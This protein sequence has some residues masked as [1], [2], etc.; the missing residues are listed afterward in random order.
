MQQTLKKMFSFPIQ[1]TNRKSNRKLHELPAHDVKLFGYHR[2]V[3][4]RICFR[5]SEQVRFDPIE[6][7][8]T[9]HELW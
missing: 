8:L 3:R 6:P 4:I 7:S 9:S 2:L 1:G 5:T